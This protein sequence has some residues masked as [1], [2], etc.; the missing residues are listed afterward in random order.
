M[1]Q[2]VL[3]LIGRPRAVAASAAKSAVDSRLNGNLVRETASQAIALM[4]AWSRGGKNGLAPRG[5]LAQ[6]RRNLHTPNDIARAGRSWDATPRAPR[7]RRW[8]SRGIRGVGEP[9][10]PF[11]VEHARPFADGQDFDTVPR[12]QRGTSGGREVRDQPC[13][14]SIREV[15]SGFRPNASRIGWLG[16]DRN[17]TVISEMDH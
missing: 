8:T 4:I 12:I 14:E 2:T 13:C 7:L 16:G 6:P 11:D 9:I 17:P 10:A 15:R 5:L 1:R 3:G